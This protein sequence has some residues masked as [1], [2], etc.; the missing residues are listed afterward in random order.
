MRRCPRKRARTTARA[1]VAVTVIDAWQ[2]RGVGSLLLAELVADAIRAGIAE[3]RACV[4]PGNKRAYR[5]LSAEGG[6]RLR[7]R[8]DGFL[9]Y[10]YALCERPDPSP[11]AA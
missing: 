1:A 5:L 8:H 3:L 4:L 9:E 7:S 2:G 10:A 11:L 6:W